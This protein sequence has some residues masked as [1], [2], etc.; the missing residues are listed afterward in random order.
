MACFLASSVS[1]SCG[2]RIL[3]PQLLPTFNLLP[4]WYCTGPINK[5]LSDNYIHSASFDHLAGVE[6]KSSALRKRGM[7]MFDPVFDWSVSITAHCCTS[8]A[9]N[10]R[11]VGRREKTIVK[12]KGEN[13]EMVC[14]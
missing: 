11:D 2:I 14:D 9:I 3:I 5:T 7:K 12:T 1:K 6:Q 4:S 8:K 13:A 10:I